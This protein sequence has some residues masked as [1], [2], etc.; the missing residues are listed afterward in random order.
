MYLLLLQ[1]RLAEAALVL[2]PGPRLTGQ[3]RSG[4]LS[5]ATSRR[6]ECGKAHIGFLKLPH[7]MRGTWLARLKE[8]VTLDLR[9]EI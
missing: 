2:T 1:C 3:P 9:V 7:S 8:H 6:R 5:V 4:T